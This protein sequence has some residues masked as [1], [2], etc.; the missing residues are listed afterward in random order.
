MCEGVPPAPAWRL[1]VGVSAR[2]ACAHPR[3]GIL[4][5]QKKA[6]S[7]RA[8]G[9]FRDQYAHAREGVLFESI[10]RP[11]VI[12]LPAGGQPSRNGTR[13]HV[14][15]EHFQSKKDLAELARWPS[16]ITF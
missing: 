2:I 16:V 1:I 5:V 15:V 9:G 10:K 3:R 13:V 14:R 8:L 4:R 6:M 11:R 7:D 12:G